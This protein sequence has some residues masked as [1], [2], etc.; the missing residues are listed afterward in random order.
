MHAPIDVTHYRAQD[1]VGEL[2][3]LFD[4]TMSPDTP[5]RALF[6]START[7]ILGTCLPSMTLTLDAV[8][9]GESQRS[10]RHNAAAIVLTLREAGCASTIGGT[11]FPWTQYVTLLTPA[12]AA[13]AH[14]NAQQPGDDVRDDDTALG[15]IVQDGGLYSYARTMGFAFTDAG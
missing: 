9:P 8:R 11:T 12:S 6:L 13:H 5:G 15:L 4:R 10:H 14:H 2:R 1:I 3:M 7:E